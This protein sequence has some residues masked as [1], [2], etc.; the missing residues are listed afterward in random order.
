MKITDFALMFLLLFLPFS[1]SIDVDQHRQIESLSWQQVYDQA[2]ETASEDAT[3]VLLQH[4]GQKSQEASF[5]GTGR[6]AK[7][8]ELNLDGALR[9][10]YDTVHINFGV[11]NNKVGQDALKANLPVQ[12]VVGYDGLYIHTWQNVFNKD[13]GKY[14][15]RDIWMPKIPYSYYVSSKNLVVNFTLDDF[16]YVYN[17]NTAASEQG[18]RDAI[19]AKYPGTIFSSP[20]FDSIRRQNIIDLIQ[21]DL[22]FFT[23]R[24]NYLSKTYGQ[25]YVYN[26]PFIS[27]ESWNNTINDVCFISFLQ[28]F[29]IPGTDKTYNTFGFGGTRLVLKD[30]YYGNT[31]SGTKYYHKKDCKQLNNI[32]ATFDDAKTAARNGYKPCPICDP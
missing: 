19:A 2:M 25:G 8:I 3:I 28:G 18:K 22:Q 7:N 1:V 30:K 14:E 11:E 4:P 6:S 5:E 17:N 13:A 9:S 27:G 24:A 31:I 32:E 15:T 16:V 12:M 20:D 21:K 23:D 10:F 26:I 29:N